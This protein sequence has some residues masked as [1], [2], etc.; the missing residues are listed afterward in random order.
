MIDLIENFLRS[1]QNLAGNLKPNSVPQIAEKLVANYVERDG[2]LVDRKTNLVVPNV[3][4]LIQKEGREYLLSRG[5]GKYIGK[6][7][8]ARNNE[9]KSKDAEAF[10]KILTEYTSRIGN[11]YKNNN[12]EPERILINELSNNFLFESDGRGSFSVVTVLN[13]VP[14]EK[15][16]P[17]QVFSRLNPYLDKERTEL[18]KKRINA[19]L[20]SDALNLEGMT[21]SDLENPR[22][23]NAYD[24]TLKMIENEYYSIPTSKRLPNVNHQEFESDLSKEVAHELGLPVDDRQWSL[25][26]MTR[27]NAI[28]PEKINQ[29]KRDVWQSFEKFTRERSPE[30]FANSFESFSGLPY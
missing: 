1:D 25:N 5:Q 12:N 8:D 4:T 20:R 7:R 6:F 24:R 16:T 18:E 17:E 9:Q 27:I 29:T 30:F 11:K 14:I 15:Q 22:K 2:N 26:D 23:K 28:V 19:R 3:G 21:L 13:G 10:K